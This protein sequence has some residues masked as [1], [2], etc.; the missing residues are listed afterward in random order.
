MLSVAIL[1]I[2]LNVV[3]Y[4]DSIIIFSV[5]QIDQIGQVDLNQKYSYKTM[6]YLFHGVKDSSL[7]V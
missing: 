5:R 7:L 4:L 6:T 2:M 3:A 1:A